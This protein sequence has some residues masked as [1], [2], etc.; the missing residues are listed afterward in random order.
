MRSAI[1]EGYI[2]VTKLAKLSRKSPRRIRQLIEERKI[3]AEGINKH[4]K[5]PFYMIP[6]K[7]G[8]RYIDLERLKRSRR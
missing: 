3:K 2:T 1:L 8:K 5:R 7:E 6:A 4:L